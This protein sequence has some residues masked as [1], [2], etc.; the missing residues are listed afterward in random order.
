MKNKIFGL[1]AS[2]ILSICAFDEA[3]AQQRR[4]TYYNGN[5]SQVGRSVTTASPYNTT[6]RYYGGPG[7]SYTGRAVTTHN[8]YGTTTRY[9]TPTGR[10]VGTVRRY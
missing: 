5:G 2:A 4:T 10:T 9:Q 1:L 3:S 8:P 7:G 6:T